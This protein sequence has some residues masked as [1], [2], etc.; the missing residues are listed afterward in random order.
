MSETLYQIAGDAAMPRPGELLASRYRVDGVLGEGGF[1]AVFRGE[2]TRTRQAVAIKV[3]DPFMSRK[4]ELAARFEREVEIVSQLRQHHTIKVMDRG[5]TDSGC[6]YLVMELLNGAAL[7][8]VLHREG[9]LSERRV[10]RI[11]VQVLKSLVEAHASG[12]IHRDL[13]PA[14]IFL[15]EMPGETDYVKVLDFGIAKSLDADSASLTATGDFMCSPSYVAPERTHGTTS[16]A[17]DLYSLG[18]T[19]L[20]LLDGR[21][22]YGGETPM[23]IV[24]QHATPEPVPIRSAIRQSP[25]GAVIERAV[26]KDPA[27]RW[28]SAA[29][30]LAA[31]HA[32]QRGLRD[33][34][35]PP[36]AAHES[37]EPPV[38]MERGIVRLQQ[39][40]GVRSRALLVGALVFFG[41]VA[42]VAI[43]RAPATSPAAEGEA[44]GGVAAVAAAGLPD[45]AFA[46]AMNEAF[47]V[48][49]KAVDAA[50][51]AAEAAAS[52]AREGA[53]GATG[54]EAPGSAASSSR[55]ERSSSSSSRSRR[56]RSRG[57][58]FP[59]SLD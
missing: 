49:E 25:L 11:A 12:I 1:A 45:R 9:P 53:T 16:A 36:R 13:K 20:E 2:D 50:G 27:K 6:L 35:H 48:T 21:P 26:E 58:Q 47:A 52:V 4:P 24:F 23:A 15:V 28:S 17:S 22:P 7:D 33:T 38:G 37:A 46:L 3:L 42:A 10:H 34:P 43:V 31:L 39:R 51:D 57:L 29:D 18:I 40:T 44:S 56:P 32:I 41:I 54:E 5:R 19:M 30:M 59:L 55:T 8:S 14:N